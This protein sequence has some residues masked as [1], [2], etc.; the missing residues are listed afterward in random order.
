MALKE[1]SEK[2]ISCDNQYSPIYIL[3]DELD[4]CRPIYALTLLERVKHLFDISGYQFV[5]ATDTEQL[6]HTVRAVYGEG[7]DARRYL[8]R[9]FDIQYSFPEVDPLKHA[10]YLFDLNGGSVR[11]YFVQLTDSFGRSVGVGSCEEIFCDFVSLF[12]WSMR[13][14]LQIYERMDSVAK[15]YF[16]EGELHIIPL[17]YFFGIHHAASGNGYFELVGRGGT[18]KEL[19]N[20]RGVFLRDTSSRYDVTEYSDGAGRSAHVDLLR[21]VLFYFELAN[22]YDSIMEKKVMG[23]LRYC[24]ED[25]ICESLKRVMSNGSAPMPIGSYPNLVAHMG[26]HGFQSDD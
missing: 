20:E 8:K 1:L 4:R 10:K 14:R 23:D 12:G 24:H 5:I 21:F 2:I 11:K 9:F 26:F 3:I 15:L 18:K 25:V 22:N 17:L 6:Q 7:F 19:L 13:D 16:E